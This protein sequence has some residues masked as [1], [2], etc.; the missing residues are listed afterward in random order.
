MD[1][2]HLMAAVCL[3][4]SESRRGRLVRGA[5]DAVV[6]RKCPSDWGPMIVE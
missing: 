5:K 2:V 3:R 4:Q 1:E 6:E